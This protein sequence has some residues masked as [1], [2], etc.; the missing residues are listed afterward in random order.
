MYIKKQIVHCEVYNRG[1]GDYG[2]YIYQVK[3][4]RLDT[5]EKFEFKVAHNREMR[6]EGL[7]LLIFR[8]LCKEMHLE[9]TLDKEKETYPLN[10]VD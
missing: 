7:V 8:K 4:T 2:C 5:K 6:A 1:M 3:Y 9:D 10:P